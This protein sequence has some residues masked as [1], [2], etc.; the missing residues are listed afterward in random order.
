MSQGTRS[1]TFRKKIVFLSLRIEMAKRNF[2]MFLGHVILEGEN[3]TLS[4]NVSNEINN[5]E[6]S[7]PRRTDTLSTLLRKQKN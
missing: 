1:L 7:H 4:R 3:I 5:K 6:N 2:F